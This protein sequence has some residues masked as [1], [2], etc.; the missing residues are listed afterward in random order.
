MAEKAAA[1]AGRAADLAKAEA[2]EEGEETT[3]AGMAG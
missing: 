2:G 3:E 1:V